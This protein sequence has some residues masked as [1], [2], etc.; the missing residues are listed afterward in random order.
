MSKHVTLSRK[1]DLVWLSPEKIVPN[2]NNPREQDALTPDELFSLRRSIMSHGVLA[3]MVVTPY[4]GDTYK[5]IEGERR[6]TSARIEG[7]KEV[8]AIVVNRMDDY[9]EQVVMFN[10]HNEHRGWKPTEEMNAI[11]RLIETKP[12]MTDE[13]LAEEL[14][15]T[16]GNFRARRQVLQMGPEVR[17]AIAK[18]EMDYYAA[19]RADQVSKQISKVRPD[20]AR[21]HGGDTGLRTKIVAK[22]KQRGPGRGIVRELE[23]I[24]RDIKD[25]E[26]VPDDVL[27]KWVD[28]PKT[29]LA[30]ARLAMRTLSERRAVEDVVKDLQKVSSSLRR[31]DVDMYEAPNLMDLRRALSTLIDAAQGLEEKIVAVTVEKLASREQ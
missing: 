6:W 2:D 17:T 4:K 13:E 22:A 14:S 29:T 23:T 21:E 30:E 15:M 31:F 1:R 25:V 12:D 20:W 24:R 10:L 9:E 26:Q 28:E 3:P 7:I 18:G 11:E 27:T 5:L 16:L 19:V 8:P